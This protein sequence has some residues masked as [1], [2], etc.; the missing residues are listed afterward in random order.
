MKSLKEYL[1]E[2]VKTYQFR[3]KVAGDLKEGFA[4]RAKAGLA[5]YTCEKFNQVSNTPIQTKVKDFPELENVEVTVFECECAY[6][7]TP[8]ELAAALKNSTGLSE[9]FFRVRNMSDPTEQEMP[10]ATDEPSGEAMLNDS[11]YKDA[12]KVNHKE[13]FGDDYNKSFLKDLQKASKERMK[14]AE[15]KLGKNKEDKAGMKSAMGS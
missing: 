3:I 6:P 15:Y 14:E 2:S 10:L 5:R 4:D 8:Q 12:P 11:Q 7:V 1:T 13:Y 9:T